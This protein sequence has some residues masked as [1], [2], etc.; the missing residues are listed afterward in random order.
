[1]SEK[2]AGHVSLV[3]ACAFRGCPVCRC[4]LGESRGY[5]RALLHEGVTDPESRR[6]VRASWGFCNW[7]TWMLLEVDPRALG[8]SIYYEDLLREAIDRVTTLA[9]RPRRSRLGSLVARMRGRD[10]APAIVVARDRR[11]RCTLCVLAAETERQSLVTLAT[12][13]TNAE[14]ASAYASSDGVCLPHVVRAVEVAPRSR[15]V[16][17]L[18]TRTLEKWLALRG[19]L[20][21]FIAK[22]DYRNRTAYTEEEAASYARSFEIMAGARGVFGND[23]LAGRGDARRPRTRA[24]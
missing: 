16:R 23:L 19:T 18:I 11:L 5:L 9:D 7:H 3:E 17:V 22:H 13:I 24:P 15:E 10:D 2:F 1:M 20:Q 21:S 12:M 4:V 14:I 6:A 8:A